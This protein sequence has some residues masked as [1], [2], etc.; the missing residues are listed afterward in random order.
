MG[1]SVQD[2]VVVVTGA[3]GGIGR[4]MALAMAANGAKV[5]VND[6]GAGLGGELSSDSAGAAQKVV[7]EIKAAGGTAVANT[8]RT[9]LSEWEITDGAVLLAAAGKFWIWRVSSRAQCDAASSSGNFSGAAVTNLTS[10]TAVAGCGW[11]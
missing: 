5:V 11:L 8:V 7:N 9:L 1:N 3:G 4:E 10:A 2:K 6:I